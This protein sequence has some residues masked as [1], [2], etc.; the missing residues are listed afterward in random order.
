M[1]TRSYQINS[2]TLASLGTGLVKC[3]QSSSARYWAFCAFAVLAFFLGGGARGDILSL[4]VLRPAALLFAGYALL[5]TPRAAGRLGPAFALLLALAGVMI[6]QLIPLPHALWSSLPGRELIAANDRAVGLGEI[7]R[8]WSLSPNRTLNSLLALAIPFSGVLLVRAYGVQAMHRLVWP[9]LGLGGVSAVLGLLQILGPNGG[10]LYLYRITNPEDAVGLFS[11]RNHHAIFLA[12]LL[13]LLAYSAVRIDSRDRRRTLVIT[14][15]AGGLAFILPMILATGSRS[16]AILSIFSL[17]LTAILSAVQVAE[18]GRWKGRWAERKSFYLASGAG[19]ALLAAAGLAY[20][21]SRSLAF[22]RLFAEQFEGEL[23]VRLLP[24]LIDT[25]WQYFPA[26]TGLGTF[27][28]A[29]KTGEPLDLLTPQYLNHAHNDLAQI[30]IEGGLLGALI[31]L[32]FL[33]WFAVSGWR[34]MH[35]YFKR[36]PGYRLVSPAPFAWSSLLILLLG[37]LGDYPLRTPSLML[38][39]VVLCALIG[40]STAPAQAKTRSASSSAPGG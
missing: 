3:L 17:T 27:E 29:Y 6:A 15:C 37:S 40:S 24:H 32:A 21:A 16:G 11:N 14:A 9:I 18:E 30:L 28:L 26:G 12:S 13:P 8:T 23:R 20:V 2:R 22:E 38:Y 39:A 31:L 10:P 19:G 25:I 33:L 5:V 1:S 7:W 36:R 35:A 34:A 4:V